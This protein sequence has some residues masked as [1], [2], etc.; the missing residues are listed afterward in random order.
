MFVWMLSVVFVFSMLSLTLA[1]ETKP[2]GPPPVVGEMVA[3]AKAAV[4][5]VSAEDVKAAIDNKEKAVFLDVRD[6][7]E[8]YSRPP[9]RSDEYFEGNVGV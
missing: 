8:Y 3:K 7:G 9:P 5:V 1:Q 4:K 6:A 2:A